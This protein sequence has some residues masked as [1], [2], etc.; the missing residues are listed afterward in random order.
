[1]NNFKMVG[2][3]YAVGFAVLAAA[4]SGDSALESFNQDLDEAVLDS[5]LYLSSYLAAHSSSSAS[6]SSSSEAGS[7]ASSSAADSSEASSS[8]G[9]ES[10]ESEEASSSSDSS[11]V[12]SSS[13]VESSASEGSSSEEAS[14]SSAAASDTLSV[15]IP[16]YGVDDASYVTIEAGYTYL[17]QISENAGTGCMLMC[18]ASYS[19]IVLTIDGEE[20]EGSYAVY[21]TLD[22][23]CAGE[24]Y[25]MSI[26]KTANCYMAN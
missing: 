3:F 4:C 22:S 13:E 21:V 17:A 18:G 14:S 23:P 5:E 12:S 10:S 9:V 20:Y 7:E 24:T 25:V 6:K 15:E 11:E 2:G 19:S 16:A 26:T 1:M 8:S